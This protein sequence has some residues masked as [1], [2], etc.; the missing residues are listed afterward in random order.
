IWK[1]AR[2][3]MWALTGLGGLVYRESEDAGMPS[4]TRETPSLAGD[5]VRAAPLKEPHRMAN[6][7]LRRNPLHRKAYRDD[8]P[9][10]PR[11][12]EGTGSRADLQGKALRAADPCVAAQ[13][14]GA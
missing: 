3:G 5:S 9:T 2:P 13:E 1:T 6:P 12:E 4:E 11:S 14:R 8:V 10:P 7:G